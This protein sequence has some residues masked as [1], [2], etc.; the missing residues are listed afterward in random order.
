MCSSRAAC[1]H[2]KH[3]RRSMKVGLQLMWLQFEVVRGPSAVVG[4][5]CGSMTPFLRQ[6]QFL[7]SISGYPHLRQTR[8]QP[9]RPILKQ[10]RE[11]CCSLRLS[12]VRGLSSCWVDLSVYDTCLAALHSVPEGARA[13]RGNLTPCKSQLATPTSGKPLASPVDQFL[14]NSVR[15]VEHTRVRSHITFCCV[16]CVFAAACIACWLH[17]PRFWQAA[18]AARRGWRT[19]RYYDRL[20]MGVDGDTRSHRFCDWPPACRACRASRWQVT[21]SV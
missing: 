15:F 1:C 18:H 2:R 16:L 9:G 10:D 13:A 8:G 3:H 7:G 12:E 19:C 5:I 4:S 11:V 6:W 17:G 21:K 14:N 20:A